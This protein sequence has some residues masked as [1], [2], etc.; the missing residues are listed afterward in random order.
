MPT[1]RL[2]DLTRLMSRAGRVLTGID[3]VERAYLDRL[4]ADP[5]P[6][7]GLIRTSLGYLLLDRDGMAAMAQAVAS[8]DW[9]H[10]DRLSRLSRKLDASRKSAETFLR[11]I[12]IARSVP[13][14]VGPM[15]RRSLPAGT[16]YLNVGHS[17]LT[18]R[19][20]GAVRQIPGATMTVMIHDT[21]PLDWPDLQRVG[22]VEEFA[23][24]LARV[25]RLAD[26]V[27][28]PSQV[29]RADLE[30]HCAALGRVP[31]ITVTP[32]GVTVPVP[33]P[34]AL[35]PHL[36]VKTPYF[37]SLGTIEPRKN[38]ALL[39]DVWDR[40]GPTPPTLFICGSRGWRNDD[41][42]ARLDVKPLGIVELPGLSDGAV[43]ALLAGARAL[44]FPSLAEGFGIPLVEAAAQ[45][46]PVICGDLAI[47]HEVLG[48]R[49]VYLNLNDL[50]GWENSV[51]SAT[52][53]PIPA[54]PFIPP[55][56]TAH[57]KIVLSVT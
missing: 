42:F 10:P 38:H 20:L 29:V 3:R 26:R 43:A 41:V 21:I 37:V 25:S 45:G 35:P 46:T 23:G 8:G 27:L 34:A 12:A 54:R 4:M 6:A 47:C 36:D 17:N 5:V 19:T 33:D 22:T 51:K 30:R 32:L 55:D 49:A 2:L 18:E 11:R 50:Y 53:V 7:F 15:L 31:P 52:I 13:F 44:L 9:G 24:K 40:L 16:S 1:A 28:C 48:D 57:F 14:V 39:L 56:W